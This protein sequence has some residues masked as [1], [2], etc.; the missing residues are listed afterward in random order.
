MT[1]GPDRVPEGR[2]AGARGDRQG[3]QGADLAQQG[4][5]VQMQPGLGDQPVFHAVQHHAVEHDARAVRHDSGEISRV[6][7]CHP[8]PRGDELLVGHEGMQLKLHVGEGA[9]EGAEER[10]VAVVVDRIAA[11]KAVAHDR[12]RDRL[13]D[14]V[15]AGQARRMGAGEKALHHGAVSKGEAGGRHV[16]IP[17]F[18]VS[19]MSEH[20]CSLP[21]C[22]SRPSLSRFK[23]TGMFTQ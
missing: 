15:Q 5:L 1:I 19:I 4:Q 13:V 23:R 11:R 9:L 14:H 2:P 7:A 16:G 10:L 12:G 3:G 21:A 8:E 18:L 17:C 6:A 20:A 22:L